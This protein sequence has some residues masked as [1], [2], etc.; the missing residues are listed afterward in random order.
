[1]D[2]D[3]EAYEPIPALPTSRPRR[4]MWPM[5]VLLLLVGS[6]A[7]VYRLATRKHQ[8]VVLVVNGEEVHRPQLETV[9]TRFRDQA[10]TELA[11]EV[12]I[13]QA[14]RKA[15]ITLP[16]PKSRERYKMDRDLLTAI[17]AQQ[18]SEALLR[19]LVLRQVSDADRQRVFQEF[20]RELARYRLRFL[21]FQEHADAGEL[22]KDL[23]AHMPFDKVEVKYGKFNPPEVTED[24]RQPIP[25]ETLS[26]LLGQKGCEIVTS[27]P[28][29]A[30]SP[31]LPSRIGW[32]MVRVESIENS[33]PQL[34]PAIN[35]LLFE[36]RKNLYVRELGQS[37]SVDSRLAWNGDQRKVANIYG[38]EPEKLA[39]VDPNVKVVV[40]RLPTP[41]AASA[42]PAELASPTAVPALNHAGAL[43]P[44]ATIK[45]TRQQLLSTRWKG[46]PVLRLDT[47][48]NH[49]PD[50]QEPILVRIS[51]DG[52]QPVE[53]LE[54]SLD[55]Y[56][57]EQD[58]GFWTDREL[59][60]GNSTTLA[61]SLATGPPRK[62]TIEADEVQI[63]EFAPSSAP[64]N[65]YRLGAEIVRDP[66][67]QSFCVEQ[68]ADFGAHEINTHS[69]KDALRTYR[70]NNAH[71]KV[72][73]NL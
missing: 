27:L 42:Q 32:L 58:L 35:D 64:G 50:D 69:Y 37:A 23:A 25:T 41:L 51:A 13:E 63:K 28:V 56:E 62:G 21:L 10:M 44:N 26:H 38:D 31:V 61:P 48:N 1:M 6:N 7:G 15:G 73:R 3:L 65:L 46:K 36:A 33:Y 4:W 18:R 49:R 57:V 19:V 20:G 39:Q 24:L 12:V 43:I 45:T 59:S 17:A 40:D 67:G 8:E 47:N 60:T 53:S 52:W 22:K 11:S 70:E 5:G 34:L 2:E 55:R 16:T 66:K 72:P 14:A 68:I 54:K 71:W 29:G 30:T 9:L